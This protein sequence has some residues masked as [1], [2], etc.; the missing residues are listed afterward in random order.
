MLCQEFLEAGRLFS[1]VNEAVQ[2]AVDNAAADSAPVTVRFTL[3][4]VMKQD[5]AKWLDDTWQRHVGSPKSRKSR[6]VLFRRDGTDEIIPG[7]DHSKHAV[8][9]IED[10]GTTGLRGDPAMQCLSYESDQETPTKEASDNLLLWFLRAESMTRPRS[11]RGGSRG[12]GKKAHPLASEIATFFVVSTRHG[13]TPARVLAGQ[14]NLITH[15]V[16]SVDHEGVVSYGKQSLLTTDDPWSWA[17][18]DDPSEIS[19]FCATFGADRP[20]DKVGTSIVI[21]LPLSKNGDEGPAIDATTIKC[22]LL[23]NWS[24]PLRQGKVVCEVVDMRSGS[25]SSSRISRESFEEECKLDPWSA[26]GLEYRRDPRHRLSWSTPDLE[27]T[28]ATLQD[29]LARVAERERSPDIAVEHPGD[30]EPSWRAL[31]PRLPVRDSEQMADLRTALEEGR[32]ITVATTLPTQRASG[33]KGKGL[34]LLAIVQAPTE[35]V[36]P[37][38]FQRGTLHIAS[39]GLRRDAAFPGY[40]ALCWIPRELSAGESNSVH[41]LLR[42]CE[43]PAHLEWSPRKQQASSEWKHTERMAALVRLLPR[44]FARLISESSSEAK[45]LWSFLGAQEVSDRNLEIRPTKC[46]SGFIISKRKDAPEKLA[47]RTYMVR[48]GYPS[49]APL[50]YLPTKRPTSRDTDLDGTQKVCVGCGWD[51]VKDDDGVV[52]DRF[53]LRVADDTFRFTLTG[54]DTRVVAEVVVIEH[55]PDVEPSRVP[56]PSTAIDSVEVSS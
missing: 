20:E 10:Y 6:F 26:A 53:C 27:G 48:V 4:E 43:G 18:V 5:L 42:A 44:Q 9:L 19:D 33:E 35:D 31:E 41:D 32:V 47:G 39:E 21:P 30:S 45:S 37:C 56:S 15:V 38:R 40:A 22:V 3:R 1:V 13:E 8:L 11:G 28:F 36:T 23:A 29:A 49:P 46:K 16:D 14:T 25:A 51:Q 12:L 2:N 24:M 52:P 34:V 7:G 54:L 55:S 50:K 17:P